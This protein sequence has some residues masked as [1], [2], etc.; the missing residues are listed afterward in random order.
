MQKWNT[1]G[2]VCR[3]GRLM[4]GRDDDMWLK[5]GLESTRGLPTRLCSVARQAL[6]RAYRDSRM[7]T[8]T[9]ADDLDNNISRVATSFPILLFCTAVRVAEAL[10]L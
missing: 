4:A 10:F 9:S 5:N 2:R 7:W 6:C 8:V 1:A 3:R